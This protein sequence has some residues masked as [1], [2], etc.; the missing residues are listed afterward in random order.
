VHTRTTFSRLTTVQ[1]RVLLIAAGIA[2]LFAGAIAALGMAASFHTV[3]IEMVPSFGPAWAWTVPATLDLT[4]GAFS[5]LE[6][7]LLYLDLP[8]LL[9]RAAV[10]TATAGT[11]YLNTRAVIG[12]APELAH[13][14]MPSVWV[15]YIELLRGAAADLT[16][17][18]DIRLSHRLAR[19]LLAPRDTFAQWRS[20]ILQ[21]QQPDSPQA[22][23]GQFRPGTGPSDNPASLLGRPPPGPGR[24]HSQKAT[25]LTTAARHPDWTNTEI[26]GHLGLSPRTVRRHLHGQQRV[27]SV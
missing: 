13:A 22:A 20:R 3:S 7:V 25:V 18:Q 9:A 6:I 21:P 12:H 16:R 19:C 23:D 10:Y 5:L 17:R 11:I 4:V 26:A 1:R 27:V 15:V 8:H 2:T 24:G 14:A